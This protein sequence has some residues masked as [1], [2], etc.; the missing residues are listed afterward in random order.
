MIGVIMIAR[1]SPAVMK[2]RPL[3]TGP[4]RL[5]NPGTPPR[6]LCTAW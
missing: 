4:N 3:P 5:P 2:L 1:I 6:T